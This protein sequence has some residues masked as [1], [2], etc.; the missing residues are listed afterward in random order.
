MEEDENISHNLES[1]KL[2]TFSIYSSQESQPNQ[3][4]HGTQDTITTFTTIDMQDR[5]DTRDSQDSQGTKVSNLTS[6]VKEPSTK[7][8]G[9]KIKTVRSLVNIREQISTLS[10]EGKREVTSFLRREY[11]AFKQEKKK[12]L[13]QYPEENTPVDI[14]ELFKE[15]KGKG[16][17]SY[18]YWKNLV[19]RRPGERYPKVF[20]MIIVGLIPFVLDCLIVLDLKAAWDYLYGT[21][22]YE[23]NVEQIATGYYDSDLKEYVLNG[24]FGWLSENDKDKTDDEG[25]CGMINHNQSV[26]WLDAG[27]DYWVEKCHNR[28]GRRAIDNS[29]GEGSVCFDSCQ[30]TTTGGF[31]GIEHA[32]EGFECVR[33]EEL[34]GVLTL[35]FVFT[36]GLFWSFNIFYHFWLHLRESNRSFYDR[37]RIWIFFFLPLSLLCLVTY[38]IQF[39]LISLISI[40][41]DQEQWSKLCMKISI[42]DGLFNATFQFGLQLYI[43]CVKTHR[44]TILEGM[45]L[46]LF[47]LLS[48]FDEII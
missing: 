15:W 32:K 14:H 29:W 23:C 45:D 8:K 26:Y 37:K 33:R 41:N 11:E 6:K 19:H 17:E 30:N 12:D 34:N 10:G 40:I 3:D 44:Q 20:P 16:K 9:I 48:S 39:V 36:P 31:L 42:A 24:T 2:A 28:W 7:N 38:P 21:E 27:D 35:L 13:Y 5:N 47:V 46:Y 4:S 18:G 25:A 22:Y 1:S 43:Y